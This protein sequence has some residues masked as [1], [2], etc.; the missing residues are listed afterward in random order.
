MEK[1]EKNGLVLLIL[2]ILLP[3]FH[4]VYVGKIGLALLFFITAGGFGIWYLIDVLR[5]VMGKFPDKNGQ[6]IKL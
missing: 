5:V 1:S 3:T 6:P 4:Y 2:T